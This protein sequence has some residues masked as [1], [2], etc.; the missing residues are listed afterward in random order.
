M[1]VYVNNGKIILKSPTREMSMLSTGVKEYIV[2]C[3]DTDKLIFEGNSIKLYEN[4]KQYIED[5]NV[6]HREKRLKYLEKQNEELTQ[7]ANTKIEKEKHVEANEHQRKLYLLKS[8]QNESK[9]SMARL[10]DG[11][12]G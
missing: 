4:S 11:A 3:K 1:Y 6:Y 7:I 2:E 9:K 8:L 12:N 5:K 10:K